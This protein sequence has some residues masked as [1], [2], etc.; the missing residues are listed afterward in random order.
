MNKCK[1]DTIFTDNRPGIRWF[2]AFMKRYPKVSEKSAEA[3][4]LSRA[5]VSEFGIRG[6]FKEVER[7]LNQEGLSHILNCPDGIFNADE[8]RFL[9]CPK[10]GK[11]LGAKGGTEG[12]NF[13]EISQNNEKEQITV[14]ATFSAD[15]CG[16]PPTT[17]YPYVWMPQQI[18]ESL[19]ADFGTGL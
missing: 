14:M 4:T 17:V 2:N 10:S 3:L 5:S 15:G 7:N 6:W 19:P 16:V 18:A 1:R 12:T 9:L 8:S 11:V 13:Y